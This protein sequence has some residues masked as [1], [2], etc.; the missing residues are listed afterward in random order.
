M[1]A[2]ARDQDISKI[3]DKEDLLKKIRD[4]YDSSDSTYDSPRITRD[5]QHQGII[6]SRPRVACI[7]E[8]EGIQSIIRKKWRVS[9]VCLKHKFLICENILNR[10]FC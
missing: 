5:L 10:F 7:M 8:N 4:S 9:I 3:K 1:V 2:V 6:I